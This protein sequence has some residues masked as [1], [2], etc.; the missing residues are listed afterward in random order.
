MAIAGENFI[1]RM[2]MFQSDGTTPILFSALTL[3]LV[4]F[5]Q[6]VKGT[7]VLASISL[8]DPEVRQGA[9]TSQLEVELTKQISNLFKPGRV[10]IRVTIEVP[11][12]DFEVD[13]FHRGSE[14]FNLFTIE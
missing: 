8:G 7:T 3:C 9:T 4:E 11:D 1:I 5:I 10:Y 14:K 2:P 6:G 13:G 12:I